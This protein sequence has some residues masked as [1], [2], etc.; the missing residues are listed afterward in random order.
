MKSLILQTATR[1]MLPL[2]VLFSVLLLIQGHHHP[3]G[4][5]IGGLIVAGAIGLCGLAFDVE[6]ALRI[7]RI[8]P[9]RLIGIGLLL[10]LGS[11]LG[12]MADGKP[13]L[14]SIWGTIALPAL[15][16]IE[17]GTPLL[18]DAGVYLVV[19]GVAVTILLTFADE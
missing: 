17:L 10:A 9:Q 7:L 14:T 19:V 5:F 13:F 18:F 11:G 16:K 2:L 8:A 15:G 4:G 1:Y 3:G 6:T 12:G